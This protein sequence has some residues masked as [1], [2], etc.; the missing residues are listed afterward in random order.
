M[1]GLETSER[2]VVA[3]SRAPEVGVGECAEVG[4]GEGGRDGWVDH[5]EELDGGEA[6]EAVDLKMGR[7]VSKDDD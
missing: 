1:H 4:G 7:A 3:A 5:V 6:L 2:A